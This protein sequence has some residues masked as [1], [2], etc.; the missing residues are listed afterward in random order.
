MWLNIFPP[1]DEVSTTIIPSKIMTGIQV[2][3]KKH[4]RIEFVSYIQTHKEHD[5]GVK[6]G[7]SY[8]LIYMQQAKHKYRTLY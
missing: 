8:P 5:N 2:N 4:F 7:Q 1:T 6:Q 3:Y